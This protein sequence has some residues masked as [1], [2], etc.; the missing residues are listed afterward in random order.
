MTKWIAIFRERMNNERGGMSIL[1]IATL[2][3]VILGSAFMFYY[4]TVFIE[5][6]QAQNIADA[7][8]LTAVQEVKK[9]YELGLE[10]RADETISDYLED[11][12]K[13]QEAPDDG[14]GL[15]LEEMIKDDIQTPELEEMLIGE[16]FDAQRDW[17]LV[18][19][20]PHFAEDFTASKNGDLLYERM[21]QYS[22]QISAA[23]SLAIQTNG[24][25]TSEGSLTFPVEREP[26]FKLTAARTLNLQNIGIE[27]DIMAA[28]AA[29]IGSKDIP[30]DVS[31]KTPIVIRW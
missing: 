30:I 6:R 28:S 25:N 19:K 17:P 7:A 11:L 29:G 10:Q 24:G 1:T 9:Q 20:E 21:V 31:S 13:R 14:E 3:F 2:A 18:V 8:S 15:T 4:F 5:K 22:N 27:E 12:Q 26:K 16:Q 23:A